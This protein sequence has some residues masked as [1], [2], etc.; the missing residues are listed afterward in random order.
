MCNEFQFRT[1]RQNLLD[2]MLAVHFPAGQTTPAEI[3]RYCME[4]GQCLD[5]LVLRKKTLE[6]RFLELTD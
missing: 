6:S 5:H 3:N 1:H 4:G 2:G